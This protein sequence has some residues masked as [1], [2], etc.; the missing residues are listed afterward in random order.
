MLQLKEKV[1]SYALKFHITLKEE[2]KVKNLFIFKCLNR[3]ACYTGNS[4]KQRQYLLAQLL[5]RGHKVIMIATKETEIER[6]N[7][8]EGTRNAGKKNTVVWHG[9]YSYW[10]REGQTS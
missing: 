4:I 6:C 3:L 7:S 10:I 9:Y 5:Q 2:L 1:K 8:T